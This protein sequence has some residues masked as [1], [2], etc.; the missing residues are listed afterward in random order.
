MHLYAITEGAEPS[1][2]PVT[3]GASVKIRPCKYECGGL[4]IVTSMTRK[5]PHH[6]ECALKAQRECTMQMRAKSGP[7][8]DKWLKAINDP[9]YKSRYIMG[10]RVYLDAI[11]SH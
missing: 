8:Y 11:S 6:F 9:A 7:Y 4:I 2:L 10:M 1:N 5:D 3:L